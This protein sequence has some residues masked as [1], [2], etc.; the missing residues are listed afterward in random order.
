MSILLMVLEKRCLKL[1]TSFI[2]SKSIIQIIILI[3][4]KKT[5]V[6]LANLYANN[7]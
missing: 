3:L 6:G 7:C 1:Y 2:I 4:Q 5:R